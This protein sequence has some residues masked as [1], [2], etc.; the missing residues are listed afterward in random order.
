MIQSRARRYPLS[1][2]VCGLILLMLLIATVNFA[3]PS[4]PP[5]T[6]SRNAGLS[7][8][9]SC[10]AESLGGNLS[11]FAPTV[12]I[13][14]ASSDANSSSDFTWATGQYGSNITVSWNGAAI[15]A[16]I[17]LSACSVSSQVYNVAY[18]LYNSSTNVTGQLSIFVNGESGT[19]TGNQT[20]WPLATVSHSGY[21]GQWTGYTINGGG[22]VPYASF[23][24]WTGYGVSPN[25]GHCGA[26]M[27]YPGIC[28]DSNWVGLTHNPGGK[29][30]EGTGTGAGA[31]IAQAGFDSLVYCFYIFLVGYSCHSGYSGWV[32]F[33]P[34][35]AILCGLPISGS[36]TLASDV[37]YDSFTHD[38]WVEFFDLTRGT[39]CYSYST[40]SMGAAGYAE[41]ELESDANPLGSPYQIPTFNFW[42]NYAWVN[43]FPMRLVP[44][45][46]SSLGVSGVTLGAMQFNS[47][48]CSGMG[49]SCF[50]E[51]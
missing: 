40:M 37:Y 32:E 22:Y 12:T 17:S 47:G 36:D 21:T 27:I 29:S 51:S 25:S 43:G 14:Q 45:A 42:Y 28:E 38:Y 35:N 18:S 16:S 11:N 34:N 10:T 41:F 24:Q 48:A 23:S 39:V 31:G 2:A 15:Q 9:S 3:V 33:Y 4:A 1:S 13:I 8:F 44:F 46:S 50:Q 5:G 6:S 49:Y 20:I 30:N 7:A 26:T 19:V